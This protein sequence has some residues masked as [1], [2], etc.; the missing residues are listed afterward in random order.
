LRLISKIRF[1]F[2]AA[3]FV[4]AVCSCNRKNDVIPD[5][6]VSFSLSINDPQFP[7][8]TSFGG[9]ALVNSRTNNLGSQAGGFNGN[10]II[11]FAWVDNEF[12]AYD[13]TCPHDYVENGLSIKV[14][15]DPTNS[16]NA[17]CPECG[18]NY[19]LTAGGTPSK[20]IGRYP[21]K[22]YRTSFDGLNIYVSNY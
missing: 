17:I 18:T 12:Y 5:V 14:N 3:T 1:F 7:G 22:N 6:F 8:L 11:V 15:I 16:T 2:I 10:G 20:G 9:V 19:A 4:I 21:L 13:R